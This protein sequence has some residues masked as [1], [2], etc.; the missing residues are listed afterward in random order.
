MDASA[1]ISLN[2]VLAAVAG[3]EHAVFRSFLSQVL[4]ATG[5]EDSITGA[6]AFGSRVLEFCDII[7]L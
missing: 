2:L 1:V 7:E 5:R 3:N 4:P 6:P